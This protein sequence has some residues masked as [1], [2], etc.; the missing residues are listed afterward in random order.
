MKKKNFNKL[1]FFR[2]LHK[3]NSIEVDNPEE[4]MTRVLE[5]IETNIQKNSEN[6]FSTTL[7]N[8]NLNISTHETMKND[9]IISNSNTLNDSKGNSLDNT[10]LRKFKDH[11]EKQKNYEIFKD[12]L[13]EEVIS[14]NKV[15]PLVKFR[16]RMSV[17]TAEH[18]VDLNN[19][20]NKLF[21]KNEKNESSSKLMNKKNNK[22]IR[23]ANPIKDKCN[24]PLI[25][26]RIKI[27]KGYNSPYLRSTKS[28]RSFDDDTAYNVKEFEQLIMDNKWEVTEEI[29]NKYKGSLIE[30]IKTQEGSR[31]LQKSIVKTSNDIFEKIAE[32]VRKFN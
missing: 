16:P 19:L 13:Q 7:G 22:N 31:A 15:N 4:I 9:S 2:E 14:K 29:Y 32:E 26:S 18:N 24:S 5:N 12:H 20:K 8:T 21:N 3:R 30:I 11:T 10:P 28:D 23:L 1:E 6:N 17:L 27:D 25:N